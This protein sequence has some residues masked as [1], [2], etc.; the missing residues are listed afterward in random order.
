M[1]R[2]LLKTLAL[3]GV[4]LLQ[5]AGNAGAVL[6]AS[7]GF[8]H[9][10]DQNSHA[11]TPCHSSETAEQKPMDGDSDC[12]ADSTAC[13]HACAVATVVIPSQTSRQTA[14]AF[15]SSGFAFALNSLPQAFPAAILRP[16]IIHFI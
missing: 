6:P 16:P 5:S 14:A 13:Q 4:L 8:E 12:C 2:R 9:P 11:Q 10:G 7:A 15:A 3:I 1:N